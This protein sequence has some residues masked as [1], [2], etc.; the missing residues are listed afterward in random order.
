M[1]ESRVARE[2][3]TDEVVG[4]LHRLGLRGSHKELPRRVFVLEE[5]LEVC[6]SGDEEALGRLASSTAQLR[7]SAGGS[8]HS[9]ADSFINTS[10]LLKRPLFTPPTSY[11]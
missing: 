4:L 6:Y 10:W 7:T 9:V 2:E 8:S 1:R 3:R 5:S 11:A